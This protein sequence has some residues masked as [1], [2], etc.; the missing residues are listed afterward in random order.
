MVCEYHYYSTA[1]TEGTPETHQIIR[2]GSEQET[3]QRRPS[4]AAH[5]GVVH[6]HAA[7]PEAV[8][9]VPHERRLVLSG[10]GDVPLC[11][12]KIFTSFNI[13]E[14]TF[15]FFRFFSITNTTSL[16]T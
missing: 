10:R 14:P 2:S 11:E 16:T 5:R 7:D 1:S 3:V 6:Q 15:T 12:A 9:R 8:L 13:C 4:K